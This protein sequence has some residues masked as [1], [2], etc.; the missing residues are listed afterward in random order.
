LPQRRTCSNSQRASVVDQA[1]II[2]P[3]LLKAFI[4]GLGASSYAPS[5]RPPAYG[6]W[7]WGTADVQ[8]AKALEKQL[9]A[10]GVM[11]DLCV[12]KSGNEKRESIER[13]VW[14]DFLA[15]IVQMSVGG[16]AG[17]TSRTR[18]C[19]KCKEPPVGGE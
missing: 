9:A 5:D 6:P 7:S 16:N 10:V 8:L 2:V 4:G 13:E 18:R 1:K 15:K 14:T 12:V 11:K 19:C 17:I 3:M